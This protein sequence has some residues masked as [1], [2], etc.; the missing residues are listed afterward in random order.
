MEENKYILIDSGQEEKLEQLGSYKI[1]RPSNLSVYKRSSP[2]KWKDADAVYIKSDRGGGEWKFRKKIPESFQ[3]DLDKVRVKAKLTPFGHIGFFPEQ[4]E[5]WNLIR[6]IGKSKKKEIETL[7]LFAYSGISTIAAL[8]S[9]F[10]VCHV[11]ASKGMVDWARENA[12]LSGVAGM[13]VRWIVDDV[14]KFLRRELKRNKK[15]QGF[16][17]DPPSFGRGSK[18]ELWKIEEDLIPLFDL[19]MQLCDYSPEFV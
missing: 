9:G 3:I 1:I 10:P 14:S 11:D 15:Y 8:Q 2:E 12:D 19:C 5:N 13:K 4:S 6:E 17:M 7:N 18:G 16:I